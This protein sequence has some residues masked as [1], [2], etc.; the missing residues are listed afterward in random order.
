MQMGGRM[1]MVVVVTGRVML[2]LVGSVTVVVVGRVTVVVVGRVTVVVGS[3][4]VVD[5]GSVT[6]VVV[7]EPDVVDVDDDDEL[8]RGSVAAAVACASVAADTALVPPK[9]WPSASV[10]ACDCSQLPVA[11]PRSVGDDVSSTTAVSLPPCEPPARASAKSSPR[12]RFTCEFSKPR[13]VTANSAKRAAVW[14]RSAPAKRCTVMPR[15]AICCA[16]AADTALVPPASSTCLMPRLCSA[17]WAAAASDAPGVRIVG[18]CSA[19][20]RGPAA[21]ASG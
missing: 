15:A 12:A 1:Q 10:S 19:Y 21:R 11:V 9:M 13:F 3:V 16:V 7:L 4:T 5:V 17:D 20:D 18:K 2:V 8:V 6:L 14:V